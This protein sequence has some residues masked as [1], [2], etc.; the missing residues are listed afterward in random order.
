[1]ART[2][3]AIGFADITALNAA[4]AA[5]AIFVT[6]AHSCVAMV[7]SVTTVLYNAMEARK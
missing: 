4:W 1:M 7:D 3:S 6:P 2:T 5:A